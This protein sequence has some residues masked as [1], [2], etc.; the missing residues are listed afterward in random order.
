MAT[1]T[2]GN[3]YI[4]EVLH[5]THISVDQYGT[6]A[7]GSSKV[8][9]N[10]KGAESPDLITSLDRPFIYMILDNTTNLPV[11]IGTVMDL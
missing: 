3:I 10:T 8:E 7:A 2:K 11:F 5:K 9:M 1:G 6:K 4:G